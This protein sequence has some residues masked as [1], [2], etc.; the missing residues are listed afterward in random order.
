METESKSSSNIVSSFHHRTTLRIFDE[1][2]E[3]T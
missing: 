1:T 2:D 3:Q